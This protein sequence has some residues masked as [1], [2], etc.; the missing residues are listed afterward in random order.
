M[1][2]RARLPGFWI[3]GS[4]VSP[5]EFEHIDDYSTALDPAG[6]AYALGAALILGGAGVHFSGAN[7]HV[8]GSAKIT[9]DS[10]AEITVES[11]GVIR[12]N[13]TST[14]DIELK[15]VSNVAILNVKA[16][17][18]IDV[19]E[20]ADVDVYGAITLKDNGGAAGS[21]GNIIVE[22]T[23]LITLQSGGI[24]SAASGSTVNL[25]SVTHVR[26]NLIVED[27]AGG[28]PGS[29]VMEGDTLLQVEGTATYVA[30]SSAS[31]A[32]DVTVSGSSNW[33]KLSSRTLTRGGFDLIPLTYTSFASGLLPQ[34]YWA[35][36]LATNGPAAVTVL[37]DASG[38]Y[39]ILRLL[40]LPIGAT[41]DSVVVTSQGNSGS[42]G[43]TTFPTY[44]LVS[45]A[46]TSATGLTTHTTAVS[47]AHNAGNWLSS[48]LT[49]T[50][51]PGSP[52]TVTAGR[53]YGI[54]VIHPYD[55]VSLTGTQVCISA[56]VATLTVAAMKL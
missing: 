40:D 11:G 19:Q 37:A 2:T 32:G 16:N 55:G 35:P 9:V 51:T 17:A 47:D 15:V 46:D 41:I 36:S 14:N 27:T 24:L 42:A 20:S 10:L 29:I 34:I 49:T 39:S 28:G 38:G 45:W 56:V 1:F 18:R 53:S 30:G 5:A 48:A 4:V 31:F 8:L 23:G 50:V 54:K 3:L 25:N 7:H 33:L 6:G 52:P 21:G 13:G 22:D 43:D 44:Q 26:G 12:L